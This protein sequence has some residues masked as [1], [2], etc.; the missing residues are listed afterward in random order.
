MILAR[1]Y[2]CV[3][4]LLGDEGKC[5]MAADVMETIQ[6]TLPIKAQDKREPGFLKPEKI[7]GLCEAQLVSDQ[8][9]SL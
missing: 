9:P 4:L 6:V 7:A 3:A 1:K 8:D 5:T 2:L